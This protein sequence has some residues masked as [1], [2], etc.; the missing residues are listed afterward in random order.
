MRWL[1][2]AHTTAA[3]AATTT[4]TTWVFCCGI[5][6]RQK[7]AGSRG[8]RRL[9]RQAPTAG[10]SR[11]GGCWNQ[12]PASHSKSKIDSPCFTAQQASTLHCCPPAASRC[13]PPQARG[14]CWAVVQWPASETFRR[15]RCERDAEALETPACGPRQGCLRGRELKLSATQPTRVATGSR[16]SHH[17]GTLF[18][19]HFGSILLCTLMARSAL[20]SWIYDYNVLV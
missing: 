20:D 7:F 18:Q 8:R 14:G 5:T 19:V 16:A 4:P 11:Y 1:L 15:A 9:V 10:R 12:V 17:T 3:A 6:G 13:V 2:A